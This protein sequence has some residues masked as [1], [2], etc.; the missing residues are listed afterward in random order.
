MA[1]GLSKVDKVVDRGLIHSLCLSWGNCLL[2]LNSWISVLLTLKL[3]LGLILSPLGSQAF[4][5]RLNYTT[6]FPGSLACR[7]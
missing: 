6:S 1:D 5:L 2:F 3:R 4:S 7:W